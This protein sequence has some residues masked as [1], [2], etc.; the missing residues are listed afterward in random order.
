LC[1]VG[2]MHGPSGSSYKHEFFTVLMDFDMFSYIL[3]L[4]LCDFCIL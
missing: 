1:L 3:L 4:G 2:G